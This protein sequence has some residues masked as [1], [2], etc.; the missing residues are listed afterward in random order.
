MNRHMLILLAVT[1]ALFAASVTGYLVR[2]EESDPP[3]RVFLE[4]T[5][6]R[7]VFAHAGHVA[8][9]GLECVECHH[10]DTGAEQPVPCG[11]CHPKAFDDSFRGGHFAAFSDRS[12]CLRC[13]A[14]DPDVETP[15]ERPDPEWIPV[16]TDAFH[17]QCL[18]CHESMGGPVG[19][20]ACDQC[21]AGM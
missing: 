4:N 3:A 1:W 18:G 21:H 15:A 5:G 11:V 7:V 13:H 6:G 16:R 17:E 8:D 10:D 12:H 20:D 14:S 9:Y 2:T 19:E